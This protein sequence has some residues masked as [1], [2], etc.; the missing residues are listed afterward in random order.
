[1]LPPGMDMAQGK[2]AIEQALTKMGKVGL[3]N[4]TLTPVDLAQLGPDT[5]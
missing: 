1:M 2:P 4:F 5:A 3:R